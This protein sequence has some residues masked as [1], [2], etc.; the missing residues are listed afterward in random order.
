M[1]VDGE[2]I[3]LRDVTLLRRL[4]T[5]GGSEDLKR[6]LFDVMRGRYRRAPRRAVLEGL[7]LHVRHGQKIGVIGPN[8]SGKSTLLRVIS[9][10]LQPTTG[11]ARV[12]GT[13]APLLEL[14]AGF[15]P[16]LSVDDNIYLYAALLGYSR[17]Q[18]RAEY[19]HIV[20]F[21][22][23]DEYRRV[24]VRALSSGM[25]ARLGFSIATAFA[26][27]ILLF[28]EIFAVGDERF[29]AK[30]RRRIEDLWRSDRTIVLVSHD[31]ASIRQTCERA[32]WL[33]NGKL[34]AF[35]D[36]SEVVTAYTLDVDTRARAVLESL[37]VR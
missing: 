2:V 11:S 27:D 3:S 34:R 29:R 15:D 4:P 19:D 13:V 37:K 12:I 35:G 25:T 24:P 31:L 33:E 32:I 9:G 5:T 30:S 1:I 17:S 14:G 20:E 28:D 21:A 26:P 23:L 22:E 36:A 16:D 18:I 10:I 6:R 8:G 7:N